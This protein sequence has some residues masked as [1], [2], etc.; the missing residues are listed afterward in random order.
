MTTYQQQLDLSLNINQI[1]IFSW[2][3]KTAM[4]AMN[5]VGTELIKYIKAVDSNTDFDAKDVSN[6]F[7]SNQIET[8]PFKRLG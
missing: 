1:L 2:Q 4:V 5:N 6:E 7:N 3:L 8:L